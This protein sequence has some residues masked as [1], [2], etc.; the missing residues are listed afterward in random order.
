MPGRDMIG[1]VHA[2]VIQDVFV[3]LIGNRQAI[4]LLAESRDVH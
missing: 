1:M 2:T 3:D 4:E